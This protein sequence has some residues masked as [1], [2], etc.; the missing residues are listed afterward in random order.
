MRKYYLLSLTFLLS[1]AL[2]LPS[3]HKDDT[4]P[5][6]P[7]TK[8]EKEKDEEKEKEKEE[9]KPASEKVEDNLPEKARAFVGFWCNRAGNLTTAS[10]FAFFED[11]TCQRW[12][13]NDKT[14]AEDGYW[15]Y[16][17]ETQIL[18]TN[19]GQQWQITLSNSDSWA[20][21]NLVAT[22]TNANTNSTFNKD[23]SALLA[24]I[25]HKNAKWICTEDN[26]ILTLSNKD[27]YNSYTLESKHYSGSRSIGTF[28]IENSDCIVEKKKI[29]FNTQKKDYN[30]TTDI[31]LIFENYSSSEATLTVKYGSQERQY[32]VYDPNA[33]YSMNIR[34]LV[35]VVQ[36][37]ERMELY[38]K[39][40]ELYSA[41]NESEPIDAQSTEYNGKAT[42]VISSNPKLGNTFIIKIEYDSK[43]YKENIA[44]KAGETKSTTITL[45]I[46]KISFSDIDVKV[47]NKDQIIVNA[48]LTT[49]TNLQALVLSSDYEG[50]N[51]IIDLLEKCDQSTI[52]DLN[53]EI[54]NGR[55][56]TMAIPAVAVDIQN[57]YLVCITKG[58]KKANKSIVNIP[59]TETI[60]FTTYQDIRVA[61][62]NNGQIYIN[63]NISTNTILKKL[64]LST[65]EKGDNVIADLLEQGDESTVN[66]L[67]MKGLQGHFFSMD[68]PTVAIDVQDMYIVGITRSGTTASKRL[69]AEHIEYPIGSIASS[70]IESFLSLSR[71]KCYTLADIK[72]SGIGVD[73]VSHS[74]GNIVTALKK[75]SSVPGLPRYVYYYQV[76]LYQNGASV[77]QITENGVIVS[78][79]DVICKVVKINNTEDGKAIIESITIKRG[80]G[81]IGS[82]D[83][84]NAK[85]DMSK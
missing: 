54:E 59:S 78:T 44:L 40:V 17:E 71:N 73:I 35:V 75:A 6:E 33:D 74:D 53:R 13:S 58:G 18:A 50:E 62:A 49:N 46:E 12:S 31:Q 36:D 25:L 82:V 85:A 9:E 1:L 30:S 52:T 42:F 79:S 34:T 10:D 37:K 24:V 27:S 69:G 41:E 38:N 19:V 56:Y 14:Y 20:G 57:M 66:E 81:N 61:V 11:G 21:L 5:D 48:K 65:D 16:N 29:T 67:I 45:P 43:T 4:T 3:C 28:N 72:A 63:A 8:T 70:G 80:L 22:G 77:D 26:D 7:G 64:V 51:V 32:I 60:S 84:S 23:N 47:Q 39:S 83:V 68:I 76:A 2:A 55:L 15:T